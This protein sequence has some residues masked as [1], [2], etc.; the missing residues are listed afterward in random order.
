MSSRR[1]ISIPLGGRYRQ[2][3]LYSL[4]CN[5][6][7]FIA[8]LR[9]Y[10]ASS[11][12]WLLTNIIF[13]YNCTLFDV[14]EVFLGFRILPM[15]CPVARVMLFLAIWF[16]DVGHGYVTIHKCTLGCCIN[17]Y[18]LSQWEEAL[19]CN[20][21]SHWLSP[22]CLNASSPLHKYLCTETNWCF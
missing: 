9:S 12:I 13:T 11:N 7:I 15:A 14:H 8:L 10:D 2:V 4:S 20:A 6:C 17:H 21:S 5:N 19:L 1:Q 22:H 3:S 18:V 16:G